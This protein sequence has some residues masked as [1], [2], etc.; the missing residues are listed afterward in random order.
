[1]AKEKKTYKIDKMMGVDLTSHPARVSKNRAAY[2]KNLIM[3]GGVNH[4][5]R[6]FYQRYDIR[7]QYDDPLPINGIHSYTHPDGT[8]EILIH[9]G[10]DI[11]KNGETK[12]PKSA[13]VFNNP[14]CF[15][16]IDGVGY[17]ISGG[18][19][20]YYNGERI[21]PVEP[22]LPVTM[23]CH[24]YRLNMD[25]DYESAN[26]LSRKRRV[27][28]SGAPPE[29]TEESV[30]NLPHDI[31]W[32]RD[33]TVYAT[34]SIAHNDIRVIKGDTF[35]G[36]G[37]IKVGKDYVAEF[38]LTEAKI[39][40]STPVE[41]EKKE[42]NGGYAYIFNPNRDPACFYPAINVI[43]SG[44]KF[45]FNFNASPSAELEYN[46]AIEYEIGESYPSRIE[47]CTFGEVIQD[48]RG[49]SRL[50]L[51]GCSDHP[52]SI[53]FS[54][55]LDK[56]G[57]TYFP[58]ICSVSID[59]STPVTAFLKLSDTWLGVFKKNKFF[60]YRIYHYPNAKENSERYY[61]NGYEGRDKRGCLNPH[62]L[63]KRGDDL[64][65]FDGENVF[66]I[67]D[68]SAESDKTYLIKR[69][70]NIERALKSHTDTEKKGAVA[71]FHDGRYM[72]FVGGRVY[73]ADTRYQFKPEGVSDFQYEWWV[74]DSPRV[75]CVSSINGVLWL[76]DN[77]GGVYTMGEDYRDTKIIKNTKEGDV[78]Y[79]ESNGNF[80][81][82]EHIPISEKTHA[83]I[84]GVCS[85]LSKGEF[86]AFSYTSS[87]ISHIC[88]S[89]GDKIRR[90]KE[91]DKLSVLSY[92][93][94][95]YECYFRFLEEEYGC[96]LLVNSDGGPF[97]DLSY[98]EISKIR[99]FESGRTEFLLVREESGYATYHK[100]ERVSWY[101][102]PIDLELTL[103]EWK[104]VEAAYVT[105]MLDLGDNTHTKT[106]YRLGAVNGCKDSAKVRLGYETRKS[107]MAELSGLEDFDLASFDF[108]AL[109]FEIP[110][111]K[112]VE[113]RVFERNLNYV[114]FKMESKENKD[115]AINEIYTVYTVNNNIQGVR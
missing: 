67:G 21:M 89:C 111:A 3:E 47:L 88:I 78:L 60:R 53:Y 115:C 31:D 107:V 6:G 70:G 35:G 48:N 62:V 41:C 45:S 51:S 9:A 99:I 83:L 23:R 39:N 109:S 30:F 59:E 76:G 4:K 66:G 61:L 12:I 68:V 49:Q 86:D 82:G 54:D 55:A 20:S 32:E 90:L 71:C 52:N 98:A 2:M 5:R 100:G 26:L 10:E 37:D 8:E 58:E 73:I 92:T 85:F 46:I 38:K 112:T 25:M 65:V 1:M 91:G 81:I 15:F 34:I 104:N 28:Y 29:N 75:R 7:D 74:W 102:L 97:T 87:G 80:V 69:S 36:D 50:V 13:Y 72:L 64:M 43:S 113:K 84:N 17:I 24:D 22:Y 106:M 77:E 114:V 101:E 42:I 95:E 11:Y 105:G 33:V 63:G 44:E 56:K 40:A 93:G 108:D 96:I 110:F 16:N 57:I 103:F 18:R 19:L 94:N 14:S 79:S 27:E